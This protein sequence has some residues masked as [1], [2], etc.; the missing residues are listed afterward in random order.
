MWLAGIRSLYLQA[1]HPRAVAGI[2]QNSDFRADP[3]GRLVRTANF[4]G[5]ATYCPRDEV[6]RLAARVRRCTGRCGHLRRAR[7]VPDRRAGAAAVGALRGGVVVPDGGAA[8]GFPAHRRARRPVPRRAARRPRRS[9]GSTRPR[10]R[11]RSPRC[12][13]TCGRCGRRCAGPTDTDP[14][15]EFLHRPPVGGKL[16]LGLPLYE[17][18]VGHLAYSLLPGWAVRLYG[19]RAYPGPVSTAGMRALAETLRALQ[20]TVRTVVREP[21]W[22]RSCRTRY[23]RCGASVSGRPRPPAD[24]R[25]SDARPLTCEGLGERPPASGLTLARRRVSAEHGGGKTPGSGRDYASGASR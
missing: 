19:R 14:I 3:L 25:S 10:C 13:L 18:M 7:H 17:S 5:A 23:S 24:S 20:K 4:V 1:L 16:A 21:R 11:A 8:G 6:E 2:V 12:G 15:Y 22:D 9:S